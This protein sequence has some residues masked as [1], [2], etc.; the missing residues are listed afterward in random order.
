MSPER[1]IRVP[2]TGK[3]TILEGLAY[4]AEDMAIKPEALSAWFVREKAILP[5]NLVAIVQ[6]GD[7]KTNFT[8]KAGDQLFVQVR[9]AK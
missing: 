8:L 1:V 2:A 3:E 5:V 9:V 7:G 4:A 6:R